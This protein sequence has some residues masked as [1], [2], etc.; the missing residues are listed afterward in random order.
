MLLITV[1]TGTVAPSPERTAAAHWV[2]ADDVKLLLDC[3]A[4]PLH[5]LAQFGIPWPR[6]THVAITHFHP[7]HWGELP[8]FLFAHRYGTRPERTAPLTLIGPVGLATRLTVLAGAVGDWLLNPGYPLD[9]REIPAGGSIPLSPAVTLE[10]HHTPHTPESLAYAVRTP[11][12][13][14]VYTGDTGPSDTLAHWA[15]GCDLLLAECS[16]PDDQPMDIHLTP[17]QA[18]G[19]A[20]A[21]GARQLILTHFYP[22]IEG[23]DPA[24]VASRTFMGNV[25]AARDGDRFTAGT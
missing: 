15:A 1:G 24:G 12:G 16:L 10:C 4:G 8:L 17:T 14:L 11:G 3:G 6:V 13:R 23:T 20:R 22:P 25:I 5:R 7:D 21:A 9:V 18:A 19:I 2:E